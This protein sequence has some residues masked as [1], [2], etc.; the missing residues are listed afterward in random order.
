GEHVRGRALRDLLGQGRAGPEVEPDGHPVV[1]ALEQL[2]ERGERLGERCGGEHGELRADLA[3][4][5][6]GVPAPA[7]RRGR[8]QRE[9][10][11]QPGGPPHRSS[12]HLHLPRALGGAR[13]AR[14]TS[15]LVAFTTATTTTPGSRPSSSADSR[16]SSETTRNGPAAI[17][18]FA[19]T[20]SFT[21]SVTMPRKRLRADEVARPFSS[22]PAWERANSARSRPEMIR[23][24]CSSR[25]AGRRP[26]STQIGR[27]AGRGRGSSSWGAGGVLDK[28]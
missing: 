22:R 11:Q 21:T 23:W 5:P 3:A 28:E 9:R 24:P 10:Q 4:A 8:Q 14:S 18:T 17:S 26:A 16:L 25:W 20:P 12:S 6:A 1:L 2:A 13:Q 27:A 19:I 7:A 15:T